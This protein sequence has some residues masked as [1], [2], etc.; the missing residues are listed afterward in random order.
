MNLS[1]NCQGIFTS[2]REFCIFSQ[3]SGKFSQGIL[4]D[5]FMSYKGYQEFSTL[6]KHF[7]HVCILL[8]KLNNQ[9]IMFSLIIKRYLSF[10]KKPNR[11]AL[12]AS[13]DS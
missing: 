5:R 12:H 13:P 6:L 4:K 2:V 8:Y 7:L 1:G 3:K 9:R 11:V 10:A